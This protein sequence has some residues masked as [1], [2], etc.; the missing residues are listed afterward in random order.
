MNSHQGT[1]TARGPPAGGPASSSCR[2]RGQAMNPRTGRSAADS[3]RSWTASPPTQPSPPVPT[4]RRLGDSAPRTE[5]HPGRGGGGF[6]LPRLMAGPQRYVRCQRD[7]RSRQERHR[8]RKQQGYQQSG[9]IS[10]AP[11]RT[12]FTA[13]A[14]ET[15]RA[16]EAIGQ[17]LCMRIGMQLLVVLA[18]R[19][20][21]G[22]RIDAAVIADSGQP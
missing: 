1:G 20:A 15:C 16:N 3:G 4:I 21:Q 6:G 9:R 2:S 19:T 11:S 12:A 17:L 7:R 5:R 18:G 10:S 8:G 14:V 22:G 13:N